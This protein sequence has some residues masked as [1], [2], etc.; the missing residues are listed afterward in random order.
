MELESVDVTLLP[1]AGSR[2]WID[3]PLITRSS[4]NHLIKKRLLTQKQLHCLTKP[5]TKQKV[6]VG[7][8]LQFA[9]DCWRP[10]RSTT[11]QLVLLSG[12]SG[13]V[14]MLAMLVV[15]LEQLVWDVCEVVALL[16]L[17]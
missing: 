11:R 13:G 1:A 8:Y 16:I 3:K 6:A 14:V 17:E 2:Q 9:G 10:S 4:P 12:R 5:I 15:M 7:V